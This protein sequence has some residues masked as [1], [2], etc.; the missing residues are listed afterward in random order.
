MAIS[1]KTEHIIQT[2]VFTNLCQPARAQSANLV[3]KMNAS[4]SLNLP[5]QHSSLH[6]YC[7]LS[8]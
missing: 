8:L 3:G 6:F 1:W 4:S 7:T 2:R 5:A